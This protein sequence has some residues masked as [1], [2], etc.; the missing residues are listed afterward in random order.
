MGVSSLLVHVDVLSFL[1]RKRKRLRTHPVG[2]L[3]KRWVD[4]RNDWKNDRRLS[5]GITIGSNE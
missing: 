4:S 2:Y 3:I 1:E 5:C